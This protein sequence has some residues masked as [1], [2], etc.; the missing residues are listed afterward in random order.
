MMIKQYG[1][2]GMVLAL[3]CLLAGRLVASDV[4]LAEKGEAAC[5][6]VVAPGVLTW[7][8]DAKL[9]DRWGRIPGLSALEVADEMQRR[10][11]RDSVS[12]LA[13]YLGKMSGTTIEVIEGAAGKG[14][15]LPIYIGSVAENVFGR[16][17]ISKAG[18][19]GFRVV[20][21]GKGIGLYG[22][23]EYGTS[24]AIYELLHR[25]GCRWFMPGEL[26]EVIPSSPTLTVPV[27]D[28]KRAPVTEWRR[29]E[30]RT[31]DAG[32]RQRNRMDRLHRR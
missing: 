10:L 24:Y 13:H 5:V 25:L 20:A 19:F 9:A 7:E 12:D 2:I 11:Q 23:S 3:G 16:V 28:E 27:M 6:I 32:F 30:S 4:T 8:G 15:R 18:K 14:K 1:R 29:M 17:G 31:A 22:E 21:S 26:G